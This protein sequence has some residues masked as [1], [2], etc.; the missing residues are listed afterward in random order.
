MVAVLAVDA[1]VVV[2]VVVT[3]VLAVCCVAAIV[4]VLTTM[5]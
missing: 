3:D 5:Q 4:P 1:D 2:P